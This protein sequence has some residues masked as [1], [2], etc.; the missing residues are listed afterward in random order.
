MSEKNPLLVV[1]NNTVRDAIIAGAAGL[2]VLGFIFYGVFSFISQSRT[3]QSS[4]ITGTVIEKQFT[5][6]PEQLITYG[7]KGLKR[8]ESDGEY[9]LKVQVKEGDRVYEVPVA[10]STY[11]IKKVGDSLTFLRPPSER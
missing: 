4:K 5:P 6:L 2:V 9:L 1:P 10:K 7:R 11:E 8:K 3:A